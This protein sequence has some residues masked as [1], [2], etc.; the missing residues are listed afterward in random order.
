MSS[1][2]KYVCYE[3]ELSKLCQY[4]CMWFVPV[5]LHKYSRARHCSFNILLVCYLFYKCIHTFFQYQCFHRTGIK[6]ESLTINIK[7]LDIKQNLI[8]SRRHYLPWIYYGD[9][10]GLASQVLDTTQFPTGF[11]FKGTNKV[12]I[13]WYRQLL[14]LFN[15]QIH[16]QY[17]S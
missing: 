9:Q 2:G 5:Y 17:H 11:S 1:T 8:I 16:T 15:S 10:P 3:Y 7:F 13:M 6:N 14:Y 12:S 4:W